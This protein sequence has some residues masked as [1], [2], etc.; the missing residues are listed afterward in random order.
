MAVLSVDVALPSFFVAHI[1]ALV[2]LATP[3]KNYLQLQAIQLVIHS[4]VDVLID[5]E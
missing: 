1:E 2:A 4:I 5:Y 3:V